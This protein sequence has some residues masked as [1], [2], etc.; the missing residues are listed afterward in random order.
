MNIYL[1]PYTWIR[2]IAVGLV[3][4]GAALVTWW[5][6]LTWMVVLGPW[7]FDHGLLWTVQVHG[8]Y[9]L[10]ITAGVLGFT[11]ILVEGSLHRRPLLSR[12]GWAM[13]SGF[14]TLLYA[15]FFFWFVGVL[16]RYIFV[17]EEMAPLLEDPSLTTLRYRLFQWVA[18]GWASAV[19]PL[20][21][22]RGKGF[23]NHFFG[24]MV[25][26]GFGA[27]A[28]HWLGHQVVGDYYLAAAAG[29]F[30]WGTLHG[31]LLWAIPKSLY[32]GWIRVL[33][34]FRYGYRIPIDHVD[35]SPSERFLGHFPRGLDIFLP[36]E[37]GSAELHASVLV[38]NDHRYAVRGLSIRPTVVRRFLEMLDLR[39]DPARPAPLETELHQGDRLSLSD[40]VADTVVEFVLLPKEER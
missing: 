34:D 14:A 8:A 5:L 12:V 7:L 13:I 23:F 40:G 28:W 20:V 26:G 37:H 6:F 19:G 3:T 30:V 27:A 22:R 10:S 9:F 18:C 39:W 2:H 36:V 16:T 21:V 29:V 11:T 17:S 1:I 32:A 25:A 38:D 15:L 33:S 35:G 24:G 4:G 31:L